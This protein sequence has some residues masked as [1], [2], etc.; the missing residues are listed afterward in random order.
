MA[1]A[2]AD[3]TGSE[4]RMYYHPGVGTSRWDR[5]VGGAFGIGLSRN[6]RDAYVWLVRNFEPGD[7]LYLFGFSRGAYTARSLAG[8]IRNCGILMPENLDK[9]HHG[10][11]LYRR[12]DKASEPSAFESQLFRSSYAHETRVKFIGVWD[13]VGALGIPPG[14]LAALNGLFRLTFHDVQLSSWVDN[15]FQALAIDE[16]RRPFRPSIWEK[17]PDA[18]QVL[19]QVW[20]PGVHVNVGGG[21]EDSGISD[22]TFLWMCDR[23]RRCDLN[24]ALP[25]PN[26]ALAPK[27][28]GEIRDSMSLIYRLWIPLR[29]EVK[30]GGKP[31]TFESVA[32][33]TY[34]RE[35]LDLDYRPK[36]VPPQGDRR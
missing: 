11:H 27:I 2:P 12:R 18:V 15:A 24:L 16:R 13:T 10:Y 33:E 5:L 17:K 8:F 22:V 3:A 29:R 32:P 35:K 28:T 30:T 23:A 19:E 14:P 20:F 21:Y 31:A 25:L 36:N 1:V 6:I 4:Q 34:E 7:A 26:I 9:L